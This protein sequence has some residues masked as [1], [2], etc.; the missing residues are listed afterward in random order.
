MVTAQGA[1]NIDTHV[2]APKNPTINRQSRAAKYLFR[3]RES[4]VMNNPRM[5]NMHT[6]R[7]RMTRVAAFKTPSAAWPSIRT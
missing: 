2:A 7:M 5:A 3:A 6:N 1:P 4:G